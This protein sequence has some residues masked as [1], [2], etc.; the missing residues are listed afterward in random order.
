MRSNIDLIRDNQHYFFK[1]IGSTEMME[2]YACESY[3]FMRNKREYNVPIW[4]SFYLYDINPEHYSLVVDKA[5]EKEIPWQIWIEGVNENKEI[6]KR[7]KN[8]NFKKITDFPG[9]I[10][11]LDGK[12]HPQSKEVEIVKVTTEKELQDWSS[13]IAKDWWGGDD[14][15]DEVLFKVYKELYQRDDTELFTAY[16]N[17]IP[18]GTSLGIMDGNSVG[19]YLIYTIPKYRNKGIGKLLTQTPLLSAKSKGYEH[20][21]LHATTEGKIIYHQLGFE[22]IFS[23]FIYLREF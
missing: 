13:I 7:L 6:I 14:Y 8:S 1:L 10:L 4:P 17:G 18:V 3:K 22:P 2:N 20:G 11:K 16:Y 15:K 5:I 21:V 23:S 9:M 19:L 12:E